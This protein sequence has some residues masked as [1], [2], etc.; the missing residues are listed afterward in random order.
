MLKF[1]YKYQ[2]NQK[3]LEI[4]HI[5]NQLLALREPLFAFQIAHKISK[6]QK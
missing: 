3:L 5:A 4:Q 1:R 6:H 2:L